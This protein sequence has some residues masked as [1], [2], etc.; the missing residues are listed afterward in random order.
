MDFSVSDRGYN[1]GPHRDRESRVINFLIYLN[2]LKKEDGGNF[3][4]LKLKK[5]KTFVFQD[6]LILKIF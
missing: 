3:F 4:F 2:T 1:R 6:F 5:E